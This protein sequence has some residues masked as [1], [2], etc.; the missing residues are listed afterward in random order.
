MNGRSQKGWNDE[1]LACRIAEELED[2]AVVN[3]GIGMPTM[4]ARYVPPHRTIIF[5]SE[6]GIIGMGPTPAAGKEDKDIVNA[7]KQPVTLVPGAAIVH[8]A[9]SFALIRSGRL[10][11]VV[12][13][14]LQVAPNGDLANWK[15]PG[16]THAGG[17][18]GAMD[19]VAGAKRVL[20]MM[21]HV[22]KKGGSKL[23]ERCTY[24]LTG[25]KCVSLVFTDYGVFECL[26]DHFLVRE[27]APNIT[28]DDVRSTVDAPVEFALEPAARR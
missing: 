10:D 23:V 21:R 28:E 1:Q 27:M 5:H 4:V 17:V 19:L 22:D 8:Q 13:G 14:G 3:L 9:D 25:M 11:A 20:V 7:G 18:G 15:V 16:G 12:L 6:N 24:P 26:G 2:G